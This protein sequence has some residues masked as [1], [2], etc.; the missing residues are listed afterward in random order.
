MRQKINDLK[1]T[2][3][4][5]IAEAA[6]AEK[7][8][9]ATAVSNIA[10]KSEVSIG[11]I[12]GFFDSKE[13]L[14]QA[15]HAFKMMHAY[16][17]M[18]ELFTKNRDAPKA[19]LKQALNF[20]F[21]EVT[22]HKISIQEMLLSLPFKTGCSLSDSN[23]AL[24]IYELFASEIAKL[25][26]EHE[27]RSQDFLQLAFNFRNLAA[28]YIERWAMLEDIDLLDK[29]DECLEIFLQGIIK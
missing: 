23:P 13:G 4:L 25:T 28:S 27:L 14:F 15:V 11:T 16:K 12:Y 29:V 5:E 3:I 24:D 21:T 17:I 9:E 22:R 10:K 7:G 26:K 2:I 18:H 8:Y 1:K 20:Y 6:F 19:N